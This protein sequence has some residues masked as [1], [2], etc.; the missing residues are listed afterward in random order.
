MDRGNR[1]AAAGR[2]HPPGGGQEQRAAASGGHAAVRTALHAA[3]RAA[4]GRCPRQPCAAGSG[5]RGRCGLRAGACTPRRARSAGGCRLARP[6]PC[7][8][9][10]SISRRCSCGRGRV[11]LP[12]PGGC[13]LGPRPIDIHLDGLFPPW[14][15]MSK[16]GPRR[17][18]C[19]GAGALHAVDYT[20]RLP[21]VGA[22]LTLMMA[23]ALCAGAQHP[24]RR[25]L[26]TGDRRCRRLPQ[27]GWGTDRR[28]GHAGAAH[29]RRGRAAA[30]R[31]RAARRCRT[32]SRPPPMR[33][34]RPV[35]AAA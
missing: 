15:R 8:A 2:A 4:A 21:S 14:A 9:A 32:A 35:R 13:C 16:H 18:R 3:R 19:G 6:P 11:E 28:R 34:L 33:R 10:C 22:T 23:A 17:S 24:A 31:G 26:R 12:L 29:R 27:R 20:L 5:R 1:R 25:G 7:A 30:R